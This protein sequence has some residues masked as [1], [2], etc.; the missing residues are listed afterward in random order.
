MYFA[1]R[2]LR[3]P[4]VWY[5]PMLLL[6]AQ[7]EQKREVASRC[8][9]AG[10]TATG[11]SPRRFFGVTLNGFT[12]IDTHRTVDSMSNDNDSSLLKKAIAGDR[13]AQDAIEVDLILKVL[14][15][16]YRMF[17]QVDRQRAIGIWTR[18]K[19]TSDFWRNLP[20]KLADRDFYLIVQTVQEVQKDGPIQRPSS[21]PEGPIHESEYHEERIEAAL[22]KFVSDPARQV[23]IL[24]EYKHFSDEDLLAVFRID[25]QHRQR[26]DTLIGEVLAKRKVINEYLHLNVDK[27]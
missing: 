23:F 15:V 5:Q 11:R 19:T 27:D 9:K 7:Q 26:L 13:N 2:V 8:F 12:I 10:V 22:R 16:A 18:L 17:P 4:S 24:K 6:L 3:S 25:R 1:A 21:P 14:D 20:E